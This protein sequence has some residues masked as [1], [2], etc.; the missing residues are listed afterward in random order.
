MQAVG[1]RGHLS[2]A[3]DNLVRFDTILNL[4]LYRRASTLR[5]RVTDLNTYRLNNGTHHI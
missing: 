1:K 5:D 3:N 4:D 2:D